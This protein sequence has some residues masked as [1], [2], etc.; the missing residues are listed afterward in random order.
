M[1]HVAKIVSGWK[2]LTIFA[3]GSVLDVRQASAYAY[4]QHDLLN[5]NVHWNYDLNVYMDSIKNCDIKNHEKAQH[6]WKKDHSFDYN[7]KF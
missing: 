4:E 2:P 7:R 5:S 1:E 3:K 6:L